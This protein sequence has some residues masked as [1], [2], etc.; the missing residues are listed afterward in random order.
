M[1][2]QQQETTTVPAVPA[3]NHDTNNDTNNDNDDDWEEWDGRSPFWMHCVAGSLAGVAEHTAVYPLD[4]VRTH[5][6]VCASCIRNPNS[7]MAVAQ[8]AISGGSGKLNTNNNNTNNAKLPSGMW[9][10]IRYL[11]RQK[12]PLTTAAGQVAPGQAIPTTGPLTVQTFQTALQQ[13]LH[14]YTRLWRGVQTIM[15]GCIPAHALYFSSYEVVKAALSDHKYNEKSKSTA[16]GSS[17]AG[18]AAVVSHD[19]ILTPLDT[20]KQRMQ[21]GYYKGG[22]TEA[23][24][25]ILRKEGLK[26]LYRSF[27]VT[28]ATNIPYGMVM[29][30]TNEFAKQEL[31]HVSLFDSSTIPAWQTVLVASSVAGC[32]AATVTT[33]LDRIKTALQT[34]QLVPA[35]QGSQPNC[36]VFAESAKH[37]T[38]KDVALHIYKHEGVPGFFRGILPRVLSHTPA[39]AISWTTYETAKHY[40]LTHYEN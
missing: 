8:Q 28:L 6:Q 11:T 5:I 23:V 32:L 14:G 34:Q 7:A 3:L 19:L 35:C 1:L 9:Q 2:L 30:S 22:M 24:T 10:T 29:V 12:Q 25:H 17:L 33:P 13:Q 20:M 16:L 26:A 36:P 40:L 4:T 18:A 21:L 39:A 27:P 31:H 38:W 15:I 37:A